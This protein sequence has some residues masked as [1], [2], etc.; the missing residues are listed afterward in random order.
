M[1]VGIFGSKDWTNY[2]DLIRNMTVFIQEAHD[3]GHDNILLVHTGLKGAENMI[4]EYIGK[5]EKFLK[6]KNFK[7]KEELHRGKSPIIND[8]AVVE[9]GLEYAIIFSTGCSRT[10]SSIKVLNEYGIPFLLIE[11]A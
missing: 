4:T 7:L 6:Q 5:T 10:K 2:S 1:K 11:N 8:M 9:S 3:L